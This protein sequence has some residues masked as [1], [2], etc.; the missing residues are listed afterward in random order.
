MRDYK[1]TETVI[2]RLIKDIKRC[3]EEGPQFK[4]IVE[5]C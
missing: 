3:E 5:H 2:D 1:Q 4:C